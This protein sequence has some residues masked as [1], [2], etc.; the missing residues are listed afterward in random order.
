MDA[1]KNLLP[2]KPLGGFFIMEHLS[3]PLNSPMRFN[4][5]LVCELQAPVFD[6]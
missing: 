3:R 2:V 1:K 6:Y 5:P 4:H